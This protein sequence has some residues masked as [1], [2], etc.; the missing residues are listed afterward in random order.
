M[1]VSQPATLQLCVQVWQICISLPTNR[2]CLW[3]AHQTRQLPSGY[4]D[5]ESWSK[6]RSL[7]SWWHWIAAKEQQTRTCYVRKR[8]SPERSS[9]PH[10]HISNASTKTVHKLEPVSAW[11]RNWPAQNY[12]PAIVM[13]AQTEIILSCLPIAVT[14][15]M[16]DWWPASVHHA[17][18]CYHCFMKITIEYMHM[19]ILVQ[20][21]A[22][23]NIRVVKNS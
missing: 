16:A 6:A 12:V 15:K 10:T 23:M 18:T 22:Y 17:I 3:T 8:W 19:F 14:M 7:A 13:S 5:P 9:R 2:R 1:P 4:M 20:L 11:T 21:Y